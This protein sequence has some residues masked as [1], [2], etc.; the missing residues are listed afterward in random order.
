MRLPFANEEH[1][2]NFVMVLL[3]TRKA[4]KLECT[5]K[6]HDS[7]EETSFMGIDEY[8]DVDL[9]VVTKDILKNFNF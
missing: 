8:R 2:K 7:N 6:R 3:R 4:C 9:P 1:L 5:K